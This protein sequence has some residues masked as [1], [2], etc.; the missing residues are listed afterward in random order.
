[1]H[2]RPGE[3]RGGATPESNILHMTPATQGKL[4]EDIFQKAFREKNVPYTTKQIHRGEEE[5]DQQQ[6]QFQQFFELN[7]D[8]F[9]KVKASKMERAFKMFS[10]FI[11][12][13]IKGSGEA[14][15]DEEIDFET[16]LLFQ[17]IGVNEETGSRN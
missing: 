1:M 8:R 5:G 2:K 13:L 16:S 12:Q 9:Y 4:Y 7:R 11:H 15:D 17:N 10:Q 14:I 6:T 3:L